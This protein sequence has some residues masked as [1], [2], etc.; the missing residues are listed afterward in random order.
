MNEKIPMVFLAIM[1]LFG[2]A[3][4]AGETI[5]MNSVAIGSSGARTT[6]ASYIAWISTGEDAVGLT[7]SDDYNVNLGFAYDV[8][9][10]ETTAVQGSD[11]NILFTCTDDESNCKTLSY[12]LYDINHFVE[13][14]AP[15]ATI[16]VQITTD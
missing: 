3:F 15:D 2:T 16:G 8:M 11:Y 10:P 9:G 12:S 7:S 1:L 5:D 13:W 4:A 6:S 14:S